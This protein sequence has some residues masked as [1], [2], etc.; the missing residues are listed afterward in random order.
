MIVIDSAG[1]IELLRKAAKASGKTPFRLAREA[2]VSTNAM[3]AFLQAKSGLSLNAAGRLMK[4]LG[5]E[6]KRTQD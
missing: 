4:V 5:L 2:A 3:Y 6:V 1:V